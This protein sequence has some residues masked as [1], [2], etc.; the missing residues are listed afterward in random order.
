MRKLILTVALVSLFGSFIANADEAAGKLREGAYLNKLF[1]ST[2]NYTGNKD[3]QI[4]VFEFFDYNCPDCKAVT[5][6]VLKLAA[7]DKDVKFVF[8]DYPKL[9]EVST[10]AAKVAVAA[11]LQG[12]YNE[13]HEALISH[14]GKLTSEEQVLDTIKNLGLNMDQLKKDIDSDKVN[15]ILFNNLITGT[16]QSIKFIPAFLIGYA[17]EPHNARIFFDD[18]NDDAKVVQK[19]IEDYM[20]NLKK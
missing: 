16:N 13:V 5:P 1:E 15:M 17:K 4:V 18:D 10:Y 20:V 9:G 14:D 19:N 6:N 12:K 3:A 8:I 11:S 7:Q 2:Y